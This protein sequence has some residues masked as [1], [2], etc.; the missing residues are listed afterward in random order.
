M[1][2]MHA[3]PAYHRKRLGLT[4]ALLSIW[5]GVTFGITFFARDL[6]WPFAGAPFGFWACA[7]GAMVLYVLL[8][9]IY[10]L[11]MNR[12]DRQYQLTDDYL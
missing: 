8:I 5:L 3:P 6:Q 12:L 2:E 9:A 4:L 1:Q 10:A 11:A 7:Q